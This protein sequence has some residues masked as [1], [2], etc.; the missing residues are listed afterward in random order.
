MLNS[1]F[2][3]KYRQISTLAFSIMIIGLLLSPFPYVD[4]VSL[5]LSNTDT[6]FNKDT[7]SVDDTINLNIIVRYS[8][9]A[10]E[11]IPDSAIIRVIMNPGEHDET[12]A[13]F[14]IL[15]NRLVNDL[16]LSDQLADTAK[17]VSLVHNSVTKHSDGTIG[18]FA[19]GV[20]YGYGYGFGLLPDGDSSYSIYK[21][22]NIQLGTDDTV[23]G[24]SSNAF[25]ADTNASYTLRL[26]PGQLSAS[27]NGIRVDVLPTS[28]SLEFFTSGSA[29]IDNEIT[30]TVDVTTVPVG[31]PRTTFTPSSTLTT[32]NVEYDTLPAIIQ[33]YSGQVLN[34]ASAP[35]FEMTDSTKKVI[36]SDTPV[37]VTATVSGKDITVNYP[38]NVEV[39]GPA[40]WSGQIAVPSIST[41]STDP[42]KDFQLGL[43][44]KVGDGNTRLTFDQAVRLVI[45]EQSIRNT[46][47]FEGRV[48]NGSVGLELLLECTFDNTQ[49]AANAGLFVGGLEACFI[50]SGNDMIIWTK[51]FSSFGS[52]FVGFG[53]GGISGSSSDSSGSGGGGGGSSGGGGGGSSGGGGGGSSGGG[54]GGSSSR[55][56]STTGVSDAIL[57]DVEW[58]VCEA[59]TI[60]VISGPVSANLSVKL[61][62]NAGL[63]T[64]ER[65]DD[66]S[67]PGRI[68]FDANLSPNES[69]VYV[70]VENIKSRVA[71]IDSKSLNLSECN[72]SVSVNTYNPTSSALDSATNIIPGST[73]VQTP[74]G[75][76][77]AILY[78][79]GLQLEV[80][81][82][83]PDQTGVSDAIL[84][85]VEWDVCEANTI[86]V[87]AGPVS[88]NLSVKL[89]TNAG[90]ITAERSDDQSYPG[91]IAFDANLSPNESF[92]Y[93]Q[94]ENIKS[95][96]A[97]I[98]SKSLNLSECNGSVSVNTYNPTS[99]ALDS[100]TNII[101]GSTP[102][103]TPIAV[104]EFITEFIDLTNDNTGL[105]LTNFQTLQTNVD[106]YA[107]VVLGISGQTIT[108]VAYQDRYDLEESNDNANLFLQFT[109]TGDK[110][111]SMRGILLG[112]DTI[113]II[114]GDGSK[115]TI[116]TS[117]EIVIASEDPVA[118]SPKSSMKINDKATQVELP[119]VVKDFLNVNVEFTNED[120][121]E[122]L[123]Q[124]MILQSVPD[125]FAEKEL[126][127]SGQTVTTIAFP[128]RYGRADSNN[129]LN[130]FVQF[131]H[132]DEQV[133]SLRGIQQGGNVISVATN[134]VDQ[135][136]L[137]Q[138]I[139]I[140]LN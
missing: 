132:T 28:D 46:A 8:D 63:I 84:Y 98:D 121:G 1:R 22:G 113:E 138:T 45:P 37:A 114:A 92:V 72:G 125:V 68:A 25:N 82:H 60:H 77:D 11:T 100:A 129:D 30:G 115:A 54:G 42:P 33:A 16:L 89:R 109:S 12:V 9:T 52:A 69:F 7:N 83:Q 107:E 101:P 91:R 18:N 111:N 20:F 75:V 134:G 99:S 47:F 94:V 116:P 34:F 123:T 95:R 119:S 48:D 13:L 3:S 79:V 10:T 136:T 112:G 70:Q 106:K 102:V 128:D 97:S 71:S 67:Y 62:T 133:N 31:S 65:S 35:T 44:F 135:G 117:A 17:I 4:A 90:L 130:V 140:P 124:Y 15:G 120:T 110:V 41:M 137:T 80:Q 49:A 105:E 88:A 122:S 78:D 36:V 39:S 2:N 61:R 40:G 23:F 14:D 85:D 51:H 24:I 81:D 93:V 64:A 21:F 76:S 5:T 32:L 131:T 29:T 127:I 103:Q 43:M 87:I 27:N 58:D 19:D 86:H 55:G 53:S 38:A 56:V 59:N 50:K 74:T 104:H 73:P 139:E 26:N 66:Q 6:S 118:V 108:T 126:G 57:Y 96:V